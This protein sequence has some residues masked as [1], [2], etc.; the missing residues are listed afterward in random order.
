MVVEEN[1][2]YVPAIAIA[3]GRLREGESFDLAD[4]GI[5]VALEDLHQHVVSPPASFFG[6]GDPEG[7]CGFDEMASHVEDIEDL[8]GLGEVPFADLPAPLASRSPRLAA[9]AT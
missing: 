4:N 9:L 6:T 2:V 5:N 3:F 7:V 8:D 1:R